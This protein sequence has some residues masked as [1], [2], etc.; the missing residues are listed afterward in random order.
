M[1]AELGLFGVGLTVIYLDNNHKLPPYQPSLLSA[2][3]SVSALRNPSWMPDVSARH[4]YFKHH[5]HSSFCNM[6]F[7]ETPSIF[8]G[9][10]TFLKLN[11]SSASST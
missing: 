5:S 8:P 3:F 9:P 7:A 6:G 10:F 11:C 2:G 4:G 1:L